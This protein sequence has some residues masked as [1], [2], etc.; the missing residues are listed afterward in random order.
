MRETACD[1]FARVRVTSQTSVR[2]PVAGPSRPCLAA[3]ARP[4]RAPLWI[5]LVIA[6]LSLAGALKAIGSKVPGDFLRYH[7]AGRLVAT[8][9]AELLYD[10]ESLAAA[11]VYVAERREARAAGARDDFPEREFKYAPALAV[12]MAPLGA[13]HPRTAAIVWGAWNGALLGV[14]F[15]AAWA[16]AARGVHAAWMLVP[17]LVLLRAANDNVNL[18]QLNLSAIAPA[19]LAFLCVARGRDAAA[20]VLAAFGTAVKYLPA[21]L[22]IWFA[23]HRRW[24]ALGAL[25]GGVVAF[26]IGLPAAA[27]GPER[28]FRLL[29]AWWEARHA[30][31]TGAAAS[32]LPGHS[33][34]SFL[35]RVFGGTRYRTGSGEDAIDWDVSLASIDHGVL[36]GAVIVIVGLLL[37]LVLRA[38]SR[39]PPLAAS[40]AGLFVC[41]MLLA[42]PEARS[43]HFFYVALPAAAATAALVAAWRTRAPNRVGATLLATTAALLLN[44]S[45]GTLFGRVPSNVLSSLCAM[46]WGTAALAATLLVLRDPPRD[47]RP[48]G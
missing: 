20:G 13:L 47:A 31:Y 25:A 44:T 5:A 2:S 38:A 9:R 40:A 43:P 34:K 48:S 14:V 17:G 23:F 41:W 45:S 37:A 28:S 35:Y 8:G 15:C 32:D 11:T 16:Y 29:G 22:A 4:P 42:S 26:G 10:A 30:V 1:P 18:G 7:R 36:F 24:K 3:S 21:L 46:G 12:M 33:V 27:L 19:T 6:A 39:R